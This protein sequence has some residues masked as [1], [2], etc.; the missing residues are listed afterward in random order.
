MPDCGDSRC[1]ER[2]ARGGTVG[3]EVGGCEIRS[4][5]I[6]RDPLCFPS[7]RYSLQ[8]GSFTQ[9]DSHECGNR[10]DALEMEAGSSIQPTGRLDFASPHRAGIQPYWPG[11]LYRAHL[12]PALLKAGISVPVGW[13]T[14]RHS[15]E[16]LM[17]A[18]GEDIKTI[19]EL[20]R[21][22][23]FKVTADTY[24]QAVTPVKRDAQARIAKLIM[25][26]SS[27]SKAITPTLQ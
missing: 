15:F 27:A 6:E 19:Q 17:K 7:G 18:N 14:L 25:A 2:F 1:G 10:R 21:H 3:I 5:R 11:S 8:D 9:A 16:T 23:T 4:A 12:K 22:A 13:H 20:L 24:T 26:D